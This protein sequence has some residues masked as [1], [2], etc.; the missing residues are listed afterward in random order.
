MGRNDASARHAL[1]LL[2]PTSLDLD[3]A[4]G[5]F[6]EMMQLLDGAG[7]WREAVEFY[8]AQRPKRAPSITVQAVVDQFIEAKEADGVGRLYLRD[9]RTWLGR[10]AAAFR[11]P[12]AVSAPRKSCCIW[13]L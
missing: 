7:S 11:C 4:V 9:L 10:F 5:Q 6:A 1:A 12:S 2:R 13:T 8:L 3:V